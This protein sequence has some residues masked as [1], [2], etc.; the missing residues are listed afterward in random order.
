VLTDATN[1]DTGLPALTTSLRGLVIVDVEVRGLDHPLHSG[2]WGG[3]IP[4]PTTALVK[5][6]ASLVDD[7]GKIAIR[8][9]YDRVRPLTNGERED[10]RRL[11]VTVEEFR[12]QTGMVKTAAMLGHPTPPYETIWRQPALSINAIQ[13]SSRK[14]AANIICDTA[15]ARVGI[16]IVPDQDPAEVRKLLVDH[17]KA[18]VPW[19]LEGSI[20]NA[21]ADGWWVTEPKG[22]VFEKARRALALGYGKEPVMMG[23]GGSIPFVGPF[24][25]ALGGVPALLVG[26]E[27]PYT[28]AHS[29]NESMNLADFDSAVRSAIHFFDLMGR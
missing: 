25:E 28:N 15:W 6:L 8:G 9:I 26:V 29:E 11:P 23:C 10:L 27:D 18:R 7:E 13:A 16:R 24:A 22:P 5:M 17:L 20:S 4:D 1:F 3:P 19:G 12:R 2:M 21:V 14:M